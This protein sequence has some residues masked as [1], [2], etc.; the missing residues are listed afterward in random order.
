MELQGLGEVCHRALPFEVGLGIAG[1]K[2]SEGGE[3][4]HGPN[5]IAL[6][7]TDEGTVQICR[8]ITG[9]ELQGFGKVL[10]GP[11]QVA[12]VPADEATEDVRLVPAWDRASMPS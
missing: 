3:V 10:L 12:L 6:V 11:G 7:P 4:C 2:L 5:P 8:G 9:V 1:M